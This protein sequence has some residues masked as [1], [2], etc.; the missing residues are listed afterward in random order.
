MSCVSSCNLL[1]PGSR[2]PPIRSVLLGFLSESPTKAPEMSLPWTNNCVVIQRVARLEGEIGNSS[3]FCPRLPFA[4]C[5]PGAP[6]RGPG[7]RQS[8]GCQSAGPGI[9]HGEARCPGTPRSSS[10]SVLLGGGGA[11]FFHFSFGLR[12][13]N[14][15][16]SYCIWLPALWA[17]R[18]KSAPVLIHA[19]RLR[20]HTR[21]TWAQRP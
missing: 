16:W 3:N 12:Q 11:A 4:K 15:Y 18:G 17:V 2:H 19:R 9:R 7:F 5:R 21:V 6:K 10:A 14:I 13:I 8:R 20:Q 1:F